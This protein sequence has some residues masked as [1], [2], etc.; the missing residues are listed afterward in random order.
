MT[1]EPEPDK[2]TDTPIE[3]LRYRTTP[4]AAAEISGLVAAALGR[5]ERGEQCRRCGRRQ[6]PGDPCRCV[7]SSPERAL[8]DR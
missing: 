6:E 7:P 5:M 1:T 4:A 8:T 3:E 2:D